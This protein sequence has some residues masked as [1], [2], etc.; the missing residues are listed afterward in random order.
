MPFCRSSPARGAT[1]SASL[2]TWKRRRPRRRCCS[3]CCFSSSSRGWAAVAADA[4]AAA[5][6]WETTQHRFFF[7]H[8]QKRVKEESVV[9][10]FFSLPRFTH[11]FLSLSLSLALARASQIPR[12]STTEF[13]YLQ[14][15]SRV[16]PHASTGTPS[17]RSTV[18]RRKESSR[19]KS[20]HPNRN[21]KENR[22]ST[23]AFG[24][25]GTGFSF[26]AGACAREPLSASS[27]SWLSCKREP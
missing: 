6:C 16:L 5:R 1:A 9:V 20:S 24:G 25:S 21:E 18:R 22:P 8:E 19:I 11:S 4:A 12:E 10:V 7:R 17:L 15:T 26:G 23:M 27:R 2:S 13:L 3:C 14:E